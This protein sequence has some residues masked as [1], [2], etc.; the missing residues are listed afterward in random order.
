MPTSFIPVRGKTE[1]AR[2]TWRERLQK[3]SF[4]GVPFYVEASETGV[5]RRV[6]LHE[7]PLREKP[8]AEDMGKKAQSFRVT[9][10]VLGDDYMDQ[11]D[12]LIEAI[13]K[14]GAGQ[15]IHPYLG[16][17]TV[18]IIDQVTVTETTEE[19]GL[20]RFV[21]SFVEAG[22]KA[23]P[24]AG[25]DA[26]AAVDAAKKTYAQKV[27]DWFSETFDVSGLNDYVT[28]DALDAVNECL[29][30]AGLAIESASWVRGTIGS[31]LSGLLPENL[32]N[33][34]AQKVPLAA[35]LARLIDEAKVLDGLLDFR[36]PG[37]SGRYGKAFRPSSS[38][39]SSGLPTIP[40]VPGGTAGGSAIGSV[41]RTADRLAMER[42]RDALT[43]FIRCC[44][45]QKL[46]T[47][48][49]RDEALSSMAVEDAQT[50][51]SRV[52]EFAD[53]L[54]FDD[55][56]SD[57]AASA[58][59]ALRN[60]VLEKVSAAVPSMPHVKVINLKSVLPSVVV[61]HRLY[62][63]AWLADN[64]DSEICARNG[65][66][67]PLMMPAGVDLEVVSNDV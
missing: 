46:M 51:K 38:S 9:A 22:E 40:G 7:F 29:D 33:S 49:V 59:I 36:L 30:M 2:Q 57:E 11:R 1:S 6:V 39:G 45:T 25:I 13:E 66:R 15:L 23:Y 14:P 8:Y 52:V 21:F 5:G 41:V 4:R 19:G 50:L 17:K 53:A 56:L 16:A 65:V 3:A 43:C 12:A 60:A 27:R 48:S 55:F 31:D 64:R 35:G 54:I 32:L 47:E 44:V 10:F 37:G 28:Q 42:N 62:G 20:A 61:A 34:L 58:V 26:G 63:E 18:T 24:D 67:R